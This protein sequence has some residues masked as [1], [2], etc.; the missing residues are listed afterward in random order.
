[1]ATNVT[2]EEHERSRRRRMRQLL[3][4]GLFV[5]ILIGL[6]NVVGALVGGVA[7]LFDDTDKKLEYEQRLHALVMFDPLPFAALDQ[8]DEST[9]NLVKESAIWAAMQNA[10]RTSGGLD[11][12][13]RD[14]DTDG[15]ILPSVEMDAAIASL[16]G[17][18]YKIQ[19]GSFQGVDMNYQYLEDQQGYL[20]PVTGQ[21]GLYAPKV[22]SL[23]K[24]DGKL[25]VTVGYVPTAALTGDYSVT[26]PSEPVKYMDY[27]FEKNGRDYYLTALETSE[28]KV[29]AT[30]TPAPQQNDAT[31]QFDPASALLNNASS[32][33]ESQPEEAA[34]TESEPAA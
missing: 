11:N 19:H 2:K 24:K 1:M 10:Q 34:S 20:I 28:K 31:S 15:L 18:D 30:A 16:Y 23:K 3:G 13:Q 33:A 25:R 26:S 22:E 7:A 5:L 14:P 21:V 17:P 8:M 4:A 29:E 12:Y 9:A 27:I 32:Q 6:L